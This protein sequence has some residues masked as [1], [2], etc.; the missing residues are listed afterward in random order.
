MKQGAH[1]HARIW[2][3]TTKLDD[4][5]VMQLTHA[6]IGRIDALAEEWDVLMALI[7]AGHSAVGYALGTSVE[8]I[9]QTNTV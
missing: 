5:D 6:P 2:S 7:A 9:E 4:V 3:V 8:F 1:V